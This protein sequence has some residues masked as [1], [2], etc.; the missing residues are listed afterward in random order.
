MLPLSQ[1]LMDLST[2]I[3]AVLTGLLV[4]RKLP[5]FY[6]IFFF[7]ALA[8]LVIDSYASR[9]RDNAML[10]NIETIIEFSL[11]FLAAN[12]Y[13]QTKI[14]KTVIF[15]LF[16]AFLLIFFYDIYSSPDQLAYHAY[17][18]GGISV[19]GIYL[20]MLFFHFFEKN[21]AYQTPALVL[22][23][24]GIAIYFACMAPYLSM[25]YGL[26]EQDSSSNKKLFNLI[27]VMLS[28]IRYFLIAIAFLT[29][30]KLLRFNLS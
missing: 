17:I 9:H 26:Q 3:I 25:M 21:D 28:H 2:P 16:L 22:T 12:T 14:S 18:L 19:T 5:V 8:Y 15:L 4:Y 23:C 13:F 7:Q 24:L 20:M 29:Y 1:I 11:V 27:I 6:R 10:Y 30:R